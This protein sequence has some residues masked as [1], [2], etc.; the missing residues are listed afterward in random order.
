MEMEVEQ[1]GLQEE[2][3]MRDQWLIGVRM[4][5]LVIRRMDGMMIG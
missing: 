5:V 1:F 4:W 3:G 2:D